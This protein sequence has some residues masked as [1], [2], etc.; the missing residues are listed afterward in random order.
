MVS[1]RFH[2]SFGAKRGDDFLEAR[3]AAQRVPIGIEFQLAV[4]NKV[5]LPR[6]Q[7]QCL[8]GQV[9]FADRGINY[10]EISERSK[11]PTRLSG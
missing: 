7:A 10:S 1:S 9:I 3:I 4:I 8:Q 11:T 5:R 6:I 2:R